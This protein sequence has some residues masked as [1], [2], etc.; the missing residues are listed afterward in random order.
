MILRS[1]HRWTK[2]LIEHIQRTLYESQI[3]Y[4]LY[5]PSIGRRHPRTKKI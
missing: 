2:N 5:L 3:F 1:N 4:L